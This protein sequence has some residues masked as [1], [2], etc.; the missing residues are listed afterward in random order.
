MWAT[1]PIAVGDA[2][3]TGVNI[4]LRTGLRVSGRVEFEG[5]ADKPTPEQLSRTP[6]ML[7]P[8]DGQ[9]DRG[10]T[11]PGRID[12]KGQFTSFGLPGGR[13]YVRAGAPTGW[14]LKGAFLGE[15]TFRSISTRP[16]SQ[17]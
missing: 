10:V 4:V 3:V 15:R 17:T 7:E 1:V 12:G 16:M 8:A 14:T 13:Y 9:M 2:D 6:V 11:P 5:S